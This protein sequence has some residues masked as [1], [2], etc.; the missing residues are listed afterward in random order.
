M[1]AILAFMLTVV[2]YG[3]LYGTIEQREL[4]IRRG[5]NDPVNG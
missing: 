2:D 1:R 5:G 3:L 4:I